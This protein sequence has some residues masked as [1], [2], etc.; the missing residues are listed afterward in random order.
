VKSL[1]VV[2]LKNKR[3]NTRNFRSTSVCDPQ[4]GEALVR[5]YLLQQKLEEGPSTNLIV[6]KLT[7][8]KGDK[9]KEKFDKSRWSK[10]WCLLRDLEFVSYENEDQAS[11]PE[12]IPQLRI[13]LTDVQS[14]TVDDI[15]SDGTFDVIVFSN[16]KQ[17]L[18][19]FG[20]QTKEEILLWLFGFQRSVARLIAAGENKHKPTSELKR[21]STKLL[22]SPRSASPQWKGFSTRVASAL[23]EGR[24]P[25]MEDIVV[26]LPEPDLPTIPIFS[27]AFVSK[28][29][30][31]RTSGK[32]SLYFNLAF[33]NLITPC[34]G[35]S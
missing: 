3:N 16:G 1:S 34:D 29:I 2:D 10:Q 20:A 28:F 31:L 17:T 21:S 22:R 7:G 4:F 9:T 18:Y 35:Q 15:E 11:D 6:P 19:R 27:F 14:V 23:D 25:K 13:S 32:S 30:L 33:S 12:K 8:L 26:D 24:R 5:G